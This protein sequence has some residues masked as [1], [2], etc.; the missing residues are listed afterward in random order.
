MSANSVCS[1]LQW[2]FSSNDFDHL[3]GQVVR[4]P[5]HLH[6]GVLL[7]LHVVRDHVVGVRRS[8]SRAHPGVRADRAPPRCRRC[9]TRSRSPP[10]EDVRGDVGLRRRCRRPPRSR[11]GS[12]ARCP[13]RP[14]AAGTVGASTWHVLWDA[15]VEP[16]VRPPSAA[17]CWVGSYT[18][19]RR[20]ANPEMASGHPLHCLDA[21]PDRH[22]QR[23]DRR[24]RRSRQDHAGRR[25]AV[26]VGRVPREPGGRRA[27]HGLDGSRAREG[28]HDPRQEHGGPS[29]RRQDQ[30]R[31]HPRPRRLRRRGGAGADD[32]RRRVA[33]GGRLGG[34]V[35]A[36]PFRPAQGARG[37]PPGGPGSQQG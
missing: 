12:A 27:R 15:T 22:P 7:G 21:Q 14:R 11:T 29:R 31:R 24:A 28:D 13:P 20:S 25:D 34:A 2:Y 8:T 36:D 37:A 30:H 32:G 9:R 1:T 18:E 35:A 26:A 4:P 6:R 10:P 19:I 3:R 17:G 23:G 33:A 5:Q 16:W